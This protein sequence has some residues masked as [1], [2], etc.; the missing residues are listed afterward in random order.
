MTV[1]TSAG[2]RIT[3]RSDLEKLGDRLIQFGQALQSPETTV[4]EL[5]ALARRCGIALKLRTVA[6]SGERDDDH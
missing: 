4:D 3:L 1:R 6:E 5:N 2:T